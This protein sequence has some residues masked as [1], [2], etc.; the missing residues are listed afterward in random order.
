MTAERPQ[1]A[2]NSNDP[3]LL[4]LVYVMVYRQFI[5]LVRYPVNTGAMFVGLILFFVVI[6]VGGTAVAGSALTDSLGGII[7]GFFLWTLASIAYANLSQSVMQEA[8]WGTLERLFM[9]P[10]GVGRVMLVN[11]AVN[12]VMGALWSSLLLVAMMAISGRWLHVDPFTVIPL[13]AATLCSVVGLGFLLGGL[14][15][16]YKRIESLFNLMQFVFVGLIAAPVGQY[17]WMKLLPVSHGSY[18]LRRAMENDVALTSFPATDLLILVV[19]SVT[20]LGIGFYGFYRAQRLARRRGLLG[21][22]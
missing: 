6:F 3:S 12:L 5:L 17:E 21:Q 8:Q 13:L 1:A 22:Y 4:A 14:A 10:H 19:V 15:L 9:S 18:L 16:I 20:Y 2:G 7:V 11:T